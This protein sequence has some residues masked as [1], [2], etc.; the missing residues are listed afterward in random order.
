MGGG[1]K[2]PKGPGEPTYTDYLKAAFGFRLPVP[3]LGGVPINWLYLAGIGV[4]SIVAWPVSL[5]GAAGELAFLTLVSNNGRFQ[6]ATRARLKQSEVRYEEDDLED[7][8]ASLPEASRQ[9]YIVFKGKCDEILQIARS[10]AQIEDT[11]VGTYAVH[12]GELR[13]IYTKMIVI[14]NMFS[15]YSTDWERTDPAPEIA[16]IEKELS[17]PSLSEAIRKSNQATLDLLKKRAESRKSIVER[18]NTIR[19]EINR[20][21]QQVALFRDQAL[22]TRD[23]TVLS[24]NMDTAA[25]IL[26]EHTVW[27]QDNA[28]LLEN[29]AQAEG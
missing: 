21:E 15:R 28:A 11:A 5:I 14:L 19:A 17:D 29:A 20:M 9:R 1:K 24:E 13:R 22:L 12:L 2:P 16:R 3:G 25:G 18:A 6:R 27:L 23:P 7:L 10:M 4:A 8:V 26:E